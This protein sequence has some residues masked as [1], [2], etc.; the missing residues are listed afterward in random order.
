MCPQAMPKVSLGYFR[1]KE[2]LEILYQNEIRKSGNS[3]NMYLHVKLFHT[4]H[5]V[6]GFFHYFIFY[7]IYLLSL[8]YIIFESYNQGNIQM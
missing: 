1:Y 8:C 7:F 5:I 4:K 2:N 3:Q 6:L